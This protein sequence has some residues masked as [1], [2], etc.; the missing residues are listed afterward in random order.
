MSRPNQTLKL[1]GVAISVPRGIKVS[2]AT[3][4]A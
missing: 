4:A 1:T 2:Q 3:P